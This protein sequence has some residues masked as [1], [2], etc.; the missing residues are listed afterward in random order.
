MTHTAALDQTGA[1]IASQ[2]PIIDVDSHLIEPGN[3]WTERLGKKWGQAAP[4]PEFYA[5]TGQEHWRIGR[6]LVFQV[7]R[8]AHGGWDGFWPSFPPRLEDASPPARDPSARLGY[9]DQQGIQAQI[10]YPNVLAFAAFAF[11]ELDPELSVD[12]VRAYNDFQLEYCAVDLDRL[13]PLAFL[14]FWNLEESVKELKRC[15]K[16]G[17]KGVNFAWS[18]PRMGLPP[19]HADHWHPI[20]DIAQA[21]EVTINFH[22]GTGAS[23]ADSEKEK[24]D[25]TEMMDLVKHSTLSFLANATCIT[26]LITTGICHK[27]PRLNF[28]SVES[29]FGYVPYL[30]EALDWQFLNVGAQHQHKELLLPSE[31][32]ERQIF[33]SFWFERNVGRLI[34]LY[35]NN[36]MFETD[37]PHPSGLTVGPG[38]AARSPRET[39]Q[40]NLNDLPEPTLRKVLYQTAAR[41]YHIDVPGAPAS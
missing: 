39:V 41:L 33:A 28:V 6:H 3:I 4:H 16:L 10:M 25:R 40:F 14:P 2:L 37:F 8:Y 15:L 19:L 9:M 12:C 21:N 31:Y 1:L 35:P 22:I 13:V 24:V 29:G 18:F 11:A 26:E 20:L 5:K 36:V 30:V 23:N 7:S 38:S 34:D 17:Y 27:F 32:F